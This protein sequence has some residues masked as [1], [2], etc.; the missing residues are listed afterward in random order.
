MRQRKASKHVRFKAKR[1]M[2]VEVRQRKAIKQAGS[3]QVRYK[4]KR[5]IIVEVRQTPRQEQA[6][7]L[8]SKVDTHSPPP[9]PHLG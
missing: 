6:S 4:A 8:A 3:K 2:I 7:K 5:Q 1:Q 9:N